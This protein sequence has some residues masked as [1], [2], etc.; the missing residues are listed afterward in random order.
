MVPDLLEE[1]ALRAMASRS[2][3]KAG[4]RQIGRCGKRSRCRCRIAGREGPR[5]S[6][7]QIV[8]RFAAARHRTLR[9]FALIAEATRLTG[10]RPISRLISLVAATSLAMSTPVAMPMP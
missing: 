2:L 8:Q 6:H 9:R 4:A 3:L 1:V 7:Q 5:K 10:A